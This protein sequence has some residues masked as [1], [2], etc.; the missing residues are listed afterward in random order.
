MAACADFAP[1]LMG[2]VGTNSKN[3]LMEWNRTGN[4]KPKRCSTM[5]T[6][7]RRAKSGY[8]TGEKK[9][10]ARGAY[11]RRKRGSAGR[12]VETNKADAAMVRSKFGGQRAGQSRASLTREQKERAR[13][14]A[15]GFL[16]RVWK[17]IRRG[18]G[19][20][21]ASDDIRNWLLCMRSELRSKG[22]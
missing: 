12:T 2:R 5:A 16:P 20:S 11:E 15:G 13:E 6:L 4:G 9:Q 10:T 19:R 1:S 14:N 21:R 17:R 18:K 3:S 8:L 7:D 22:K